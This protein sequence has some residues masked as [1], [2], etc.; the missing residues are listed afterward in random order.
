MNDRGGG[1]R[2][3]PVVMIG[4]AALVAVAVFRVPLATVFTFG[5]LLICP[6]MMF[7][8]H[9]SHAD[10]GQAHEDGGSP[11]DGEPHQHLARR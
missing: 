10:R 4:V 7:G 11:G 1:G 2:L 5:V 3:R 8:M 6:L 9:G